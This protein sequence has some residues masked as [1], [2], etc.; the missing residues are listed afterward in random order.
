MLGKDPTSVQNALH[1]GTEKGMELC[2][3]EG[4]HSYDAGHEISNT[5]SEQFDSKN[6][7]GPCLALTVCPLYEIAMI[8]YTI[9]ADQTYTAIH[10]P[11]ALVEDTLIGNNIQPISHNHNDN[12][13]SLIYPT[14]GTGSYLTLSLLW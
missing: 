11:N 9:I 10:Q 2:I 1:A 4:L 12:I 6:S 14:Y 3:I 13:K 5:A 8:Q 7:I